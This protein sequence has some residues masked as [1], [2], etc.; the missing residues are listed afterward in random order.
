MSHEHRHHRRS[1]DDTPP[2]TR[3]GSHLTHYVMITGCN[4]LDYP[5]TVYSISGVGD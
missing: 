2:R 3:V 1:K 5:L 4:R